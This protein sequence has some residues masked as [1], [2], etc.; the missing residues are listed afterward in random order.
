MGHQGVPQ[1][2]KKE[3][4]EDGWKQGSAL[5]RVLGSRGE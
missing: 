3:H 4:S 5:D 2:H 1:A